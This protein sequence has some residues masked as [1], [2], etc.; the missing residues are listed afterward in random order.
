VTDGGLSKRPR[1]KDEIYAFAL[2]SP[3]LVGFLLFTAGP[4]LMSMYLSL[5]EWRLIGEPRWVGLENFRVL[6]SEDPR[7]WKALYNTAYYTLFSV[8][9]GLVVALLLALLLNQ[10][11]RGIRFFRTAFYVPVVTSG[12]ATSLLWLWIFNPRLGLLNYFLGLL[13]IEGPSWLVSDLWSKPAFILMSLWG[14]GGPMVVFLAALQSIPQHL[15][16]AAMIDGANRWQ[17]FRHITL[18]II[19]PTTFFLLVMGIIGSFQ[20]FTSAFVMT[21][22]GPADSTLFYVLYLYENAFQHFRMGYASALA[23][24]LFVI[25]L[26]FTVLQFKVAGK[27]V[28]YENLR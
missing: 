10:Q 19:S 11:L 14:V 26:G 7:F 8:P 6:F 22:G 24:V 13:G 27:W 28:H 20:I 1:R 17:M 2:I 12:V 9:L 5:T 18:P 21:K 4:M 16:E 25:I 3:W 15:F 23:W